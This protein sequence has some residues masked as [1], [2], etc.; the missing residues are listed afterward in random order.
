[1][2]STTLA[3]VE[4]LL[5]PAED[6]SGGDNLDEAV[7]SMIEPDDGQSEEVEVEDE[8]QDDVAASSDDDYDDVEIDDEDPVEAQAEDTN[9]IPVKVDGKEEMWTLDQ[10]KQSA[11]GQAAINKRFQEAAEARKQIEQQASA[12]QQQQQHIVQ[13]YQQAQQGGLQAPTPPTRELFESDPIGYMEEKLKF[14]EA[15]AQYDQNM[16]QYQAV[17]QQQTQTQRAAEQAH[18]QEQAEELQRY[19]PEFADPEKRSAFIQN[20]SNKAKQHYGLTDDQIGTVK[21]AVE[22]RILSDAIKYRELVAKR[23]S[24]QSKGEKARPVVKAGAKKRSDNAVDTRKKAQV[25]LQKT[26]SDADALSLMFKQ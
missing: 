6:N 17:Q 4:S 1:M 11:A 10:L 21:T 13:L 7:N 15:K 23:K 16:Y 26:G 22:T 19:I 12:L 14:D 5:A 2:D 8:D 25:R 20:T 24:V 18:L 9:F 3:A